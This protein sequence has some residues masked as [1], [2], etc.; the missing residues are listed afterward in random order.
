MASHFEYLLTITNTLG[1]TSVSLQTPPSTMLFL[2]QSMPAINIL[3][4]EGAD[5]ATFDKNNISG[6]PQGTLRILFLNLMP[7]KAVTELDIARVICRHHRPAALLP[8]K[9]AN[10]T[11]KTTPPEHM[12]RF[13]TD[14]EYFENAP[15]PHFDG[16]IVTGAP[17]EHLPFENVRYWTQ[18]CHIMNWAEAHVRSTLYICWGAQAA[19]QHLYGI[20]K[21]QLPAKKFGVFIQKKLAGDA[22]IL[23]HLPENFPMPNSRHTEV[24]RKDIERHPLHI[25]AESE[26]SGVGIVTSADGTQQIFIVGHLEYEPKTLHNEYQR[27]LSKD[28]PSLP[29]SI[30]TTTTNRKKASTSH[31]KKRPPRSIAIGLTSVAKRPCASSENRNHQTMNKKNIAAGRTQKQIPPHFYYRRNTK[32]LNFILNF[33]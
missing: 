28:S 11:Y 20:P 6:F 7:Q 33:A 9:I 30:I 2:P 27:D 16:M 10:Q 29:H 32:I 12:E 21:H 19:L 14:F 22:P 25:V 15:N 5:I 24:Q 13:Y 4:K 31:G 26:E 3:R 8:M 23:R 17:V 1:F 18:L